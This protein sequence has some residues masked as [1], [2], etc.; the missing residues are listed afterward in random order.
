VVTGVETGLVPHR[1]AT[2]VAARA[3]EAR[4]LHVALT[5]ASDRL[6][7]TWA[8]RRGGYRRKPSPLLAGLTVDAPAPPRP[9]LDITALHRDEEDAPLKRLVAWR[10]EA[11]RAA[12]VLPGELCSDRDLAVIAGASPRSPEELAAVTGF[13]PLTAA[14]L[15]PPIRSALDGA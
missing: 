6:I 3:E 9:P 1:S 7:V 13:G 8:A 12:A 5:R 2:T 14:R 11:A 4:L 10:H 15:F